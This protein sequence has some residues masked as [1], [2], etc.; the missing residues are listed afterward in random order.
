MPRLILFS[1]LPLVIGLLLLARLAPELVLR[2]AHCPW[3]ETTG[4]PCPTC[5][6]T[7]AAT[8]L[9]H[10]QL[11]TALRANP[12]VMLLGLVFAAG[13]AYAVVA[14][15]VPRWRRSLALTTGESRTARWLAALLLVLNWIWLTVRYLG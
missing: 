1:L 12:L 4:F 7:L 8:A 3:R 5:G 13:A 11:G 9:V 15:L 2:V 10:G 6:S 14:T